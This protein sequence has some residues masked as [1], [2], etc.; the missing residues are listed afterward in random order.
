MKNLL[1]FACTVA[2]SLSA[3]SANAHDLWLKPSSTVLS[4]T[5]TWVTVD[6]AVSNE[7]FYFNH[8]ALRLDGLQISAPDGTQAEP[9]NASQGKLRSTFDL[10]LSQAGTYRIAVV[11]DGVFARWQENGQP[12]RYFGKADGLNAA[13]PAKAENLTI[14]Q[15]LGR[16][17]TFVTA[18][19]P[20]AIA[21]QSK[22]LSLQPI[23]H[24][25]DLY[26]G[27]AAAFRLMLDGK[28]A[29]GVKVTVVADGSRYRDNVNETTYTSDSKGEF[30]V[31]WSHPG[32]YWLQA[33]YD[34]KLVTVPQASTR[35]LSYSATL[36]VLPL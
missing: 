36:E 29:A 8:A 32:L 4:G 27:E 21:D 13:V 1:R 3:A 34:D 35:H 31:T 12:K 30:K 10:Q 24:P 17:E 14:T 6:A 33:E 11:N 16:V 28:P 22:G 26:S 19:K 23:T 7:K 9:A 2:L 5:D 15:R 25:N 18:G 20:S